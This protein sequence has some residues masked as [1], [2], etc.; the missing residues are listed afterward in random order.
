MRSIHS[1]LARALDISLPAEVRAKESELA[2]VDLQECQELVELMRFEANVHPTERSR[3]L[4]NIAVCQ[5]QLDAARGL[6]LRLTAEPM[7]RSRSLSAPS[8]L[9]ADKRALFSEPGPLRIDQASVGQMLAQRQA[10]KDTAALMES[11]T[12]ALREA[13]ATI[14]RI[15]STNGATL[16]EL[17]EQKATLLRIKGKLQSVNDHLGESENWMRKID[18]ALSWFSFSS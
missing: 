2:R 6:L 7:A 10:V 17:H 3:G 9:A 14:H 4:E 18:K 11:D 1:H 13:L 8:Q 5:V 12:E 16:A 15:K